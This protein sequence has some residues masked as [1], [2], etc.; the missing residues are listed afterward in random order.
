MIEIWPTIDLIDQQSVRLTEGVYDSK[1][2][3][4]RSPKEAISFYNRFKQVTRI[5][6]VD[7]MGALHKKPSDKTF[8]KELIESSTSP[9]EIG[10]G[11]RSLPIQWCLL[12]HRRHA[13]TAGQSVA[14]R[15]DYA[16][17]RQ[18]LSGT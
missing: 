6:I 4:K 12:R 7:L 5:H 13:G 8:I 17:S 9:V 18:D 10:G 2:V 11:I 15:N 14:G 3:M 1:E 16:L